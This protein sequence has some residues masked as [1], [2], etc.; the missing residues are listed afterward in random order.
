MGLNLLLGCAD[1]A[2]S[3]DLPRRGVSLFAFNYTDRY[4]G[5]VKVDG[6]WLGGA[7]AHGNSGSAAGLSAPRDRNKRHSIEVS[8]IVADV[9]DLATNKYQRRPD[10]PHTANVELAFPYPDNPNELVLHFYP[11]GHVEAELIGEKDRW[12]TFRRI[13]PPQGYTR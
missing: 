7:D 10:E 3:G 4:V 8:W 13:P 11:D 1:M 9:Y 6:M 2:R 5:D 12:W